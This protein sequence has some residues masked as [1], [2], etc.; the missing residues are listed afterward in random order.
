MNERIIDNVDYLLGLSED[1]LN[2]L[3]IDDKY[4]KANLRELVKRTLKYANDYKKAFEYEISV[5]KKEV[6]K[7]LALYNR[8]IIE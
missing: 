5:E 6:D 4:N 2:E 3:L 8:K 1:E 7:Q